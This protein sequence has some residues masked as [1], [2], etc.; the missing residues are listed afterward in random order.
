M[1]YLLL[2]LIAAGVAVPAI[3]LSSARTDHSGHYYLQGVMETG[4]EL[5]L[6]PDGR[7]QWYLSY[8]A[9]DLFAEG[10]WS[11]KD[12]IV[13]LTAEKTKDVP[14]PGFETLQLTIRDADL[15][16]PDGHG[17]YVLPTSRED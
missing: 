6:R 14:E 1:R 17:A 15:I 2:A 7:F 12:G 16:P 3:A 10:R 9:L 4:S 5:L 8:G 11:E 13:L